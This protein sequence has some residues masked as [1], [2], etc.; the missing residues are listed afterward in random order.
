MRTIFAFLFIIG[1]T[2][3]FV[4]A[5]DIRSILSG[6]P[7]E[8]EDVGQPQDLDIDTASPTCESDWVAKMA[9]DDPLMLMEVMSVVSTFEHIQ[10]LERGGLSKTLCLPN[11][12]G[13][14]TGF[15]T[16]SDPQEI[17]QFYCENPAEVQLQSLP[18]TYACALAE[19]ELRET[20]LGSMILGVE[21]DYEQ[22][23]KVISDVMTDQSAA[24][25]GMGKIFT[26]L[27]E[28][29]TGVIVV[30]GGK[31]VLNLAEL[32]AKEQAKLNQTREIGIAT[33]R[34]DN[35]RDQRQ[36]LEEMRD[37]QR[38]FLDRNEPIGE[39]AR[40]VNEQFAERLET[41]VQDATEREEKAERVLS[42]VT[43][44]ECQTVAGCKPD[45]EINTCEDEACV[46]AQIAE[47]FD[48]AEAI[49]QSCEVQISPVNPEPPSQ[50]PQDDSYGA[51][52]QQLL[53]GCQTVLVEDP[54]MAAGDPDGCGETTDPYAEID[55]NEVVREKFVETFLANGEV[56]CQLDDMNCQIAVKLQQK[57][58]L[59]ETEL[60]FTSSQCGIENDGNLNFDPE[61]ALAQP[62]SEPNGC[63][64]RFSHKQVCGAEAE[65]IRFIWSRPDIT[66]WNFRFQML[67]NMQCMN[68][69][70]VAD[71]VE[72]R[73]S[74]SPN[75]DR[76]PFIDGTSM[77]DLPEQFAN[78]IEELSELFEIDPEDVKITRAGE[79]EAIGSPHDPFVTVVLGMDDPDGRAFKDF[80]C[81]RL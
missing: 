19:Q 3:T 30:E 11:G 39:D 45:P 53:Q 4:A 49:I 70:S 17:G 8:P 57:M 73:Y 46:A 62:G 24:I 7:K 6:F 59:S 23:M 13:T 5:Q 27:V 26:T 33:Q 81:E 31:E 10:A 54:C 77:D 37:I 9:A 15:V 66:R 14:T 72:S 78:P 40:A 47:R 21:P 61:E 32:A 41:N 74:F 36:E 12:T 65:C 55:V 79:I 28:I 35:L 64:D 22:Q 43:S 51:L 42:A 80:V 69:E 76:S 67:R 1:A 50:L 29:G 60:L 71:I 20:G 44:G 34:R 2:S 52:G 75:A 38:D 25:D 16:E 58:P 63:L 68:F 48:D 56:P 18:N